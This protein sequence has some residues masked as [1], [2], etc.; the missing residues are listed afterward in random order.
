[1][2]LLFSVAAYGQTQQDFL[3]SLVDQKL[4]LRGIADRK[5]AKVKKKDLARL[6]GTCDVAVQVKQALWDQGKV[7]FRLEEI[8]TPYLPGK[9]RSTCQTTYDHGTLEISGFAADE[10]TDSLAASI[11]QA[12][13][14]PEQYLAVR[15]VPFDVKP[16]SAESIESKPPERMSSTIT[17]PKEVLGIDP[18]Y[19]EEARKGKIQ[20]LVVLSVVVGAD[21][22]IHDSKVSRKAGY[23]LDENAMNVLS[24]WR[25]EPGRKQ[26]KPVPVQLNLQMS[27]NIY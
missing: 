11:S 22:Q 2:A 18:A 17:M 7:S 10:T 20:G 27:F 26:D 6:N 1:M 14:T 3:H 25:F 16:V 23:G 21:G 19:T 13:Q 12:L 8:G 5:E 9:P 24:L 15:G 4:I